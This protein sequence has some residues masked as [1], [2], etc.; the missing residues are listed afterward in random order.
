M[1]TFKE[2]RMGI[3]LFTFGGLVA[4]LRSL[5]Q[6]LVRPPPEPSRTPQCEAATSFTATRSA[7][8]GR[9]E[10]LRRPLRVVRVVEAS[11]VPAGAGRMFISGRMSDVCAE[12][13]R[14]AALEAAAG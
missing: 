3:A 12:L 5:A 2:S 7:L 11:R 8:S 1:T 14:L 13:E 9:G 4:P 6:W 10:A